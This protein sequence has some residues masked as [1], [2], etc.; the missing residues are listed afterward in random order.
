MKKIATALGLIS[1]LFSNS[2]QAQNVDI[3]NLNL[4]AAGLRGHSKIDSTLPTRQTLAIVGEINVAGRYSRTRNKITF[5]PE[6][7]GGKSA[8]LSVETGGLNIGVIRIGPYAKY[9]YAK[10]KDLVWDYRN[11]LITGET[12]KQYLFLGFNAGIGS[13]SQRNVRLYAGA[14][15]TEMNK[16]IRSFAD[17]RE[18]M[19]SPTLVDKDLLPVVM[20]GGSIVWPDFW[21]KIDLFASVSN[22]RTIKNIRAIR[23]INLENTKKIIPENQIITDLEIKRPI[24]FWLEI[25]ANLNLINNE[26]GVVFLGNSLTTKLVFKF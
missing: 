15:A 13:Y 19:G 6:K 18:I 21:Q 22:I 24:T 9:F 16:I 17:G 3:L 23:A 25:G 12:R 2:A 14:G 7:F 1:L 5:G 8:D 26:L 20:V 11:L 4:G 10:D